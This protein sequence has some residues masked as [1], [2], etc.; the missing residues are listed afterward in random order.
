[1]RIGELSE[2]TGASVRSLRY[3]EKKGLIFGERL[4]NGY[5]DF[6]ETQIER[7]RAVRFYLGLGLS[8]E[9]NEVILN[10]KGK[11]AP[12]EKAPEMNEQCEELLILYEEKLSEMDEQLESFSEARS[13]LKKRI[14]LFQEHR[15][16][17][18]SRVSR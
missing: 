1:M 6:D 2:R 5:R 8:T 14:A 16:E 12:P 4:E 17:V 15:D 9:S 7:V 13:R 10:C 11:D 18:R 3:Y